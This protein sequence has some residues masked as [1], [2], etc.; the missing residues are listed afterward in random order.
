MSDNSSSGAPKRGLTSDWAE[1][2]I[3]ANTWATDTG[4]RMR[5][6]RDTVPNSPTVTR[7]LGFTY[8]W[9]ITE[10]QAVRLDRFPWPGA[11]DVPAEGVPF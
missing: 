2:I 7:L 8:G 6:A 4:R 1:A 11:V 9:N 10:V 3:V 5:V